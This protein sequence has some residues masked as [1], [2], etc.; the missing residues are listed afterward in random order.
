MIGAVLEAT[1]LCRGRRKC[2]GVAS[3]NRVWFV[4]CMGPSQGRDKSTLLNPSK[5]Q[6]MT[7][8]LDEPSALVTR[9]Y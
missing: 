6:D 4:D 8:W 3:D 2:R 9:V 7:A 1:G 5:G